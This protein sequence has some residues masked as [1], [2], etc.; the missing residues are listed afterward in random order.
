MRRLL[1]DLANYLAELAGA[2]RKGWNAFFFYRRRPDDG[3]VDSRGRW[4][5]WRSGACWSSGWTCT[6]ISAATAGLT[7]A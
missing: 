7:R 1:N 5:C 2:T 6:T 4:A 3:W